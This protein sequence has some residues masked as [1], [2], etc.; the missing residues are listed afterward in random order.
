MKNSKRFNVLAIMVMI[1]TILLDGVLGYQFYRESKAVE[2]KD[3]IGHQAKELYE[4][5]GTLNPKYACKITYETT[6]DHAKDLIF[7][8]SAAAG[9]KIKSD[10]A[11][12]ISSGLIESIDRPMID[13][14]TTRLDIERWAS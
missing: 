5:C 8:Q 12:K 9:E 6:K 14:N 4:W 7:Y 2:A 10:I 11:F 1:L 3:F 13:G